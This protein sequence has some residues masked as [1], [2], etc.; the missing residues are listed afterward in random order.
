[1]KKVSYERRDYDPVDEKSLSWA[2][3]QKTTKKEF[4]K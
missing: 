1:M 2:M 3:P 4:V